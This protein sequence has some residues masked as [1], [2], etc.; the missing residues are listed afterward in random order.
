MSI[1]VCDC[2]C[3][4]SLWLRI[5]LS[6]SFVEQQAAEKPPSCHSSSWITMWRE[7]CPVIW[8]SLSHAKSA[9]PALPAGWHVNANAPWAAWWGIRYEM[10]AVESS[11]VR[12]LNELFFYAGNRSSRSQIRTEVTFTWQQCTKKEKSFPSRV[13]LTHYVKMMTFTRISQN[14][15]NGGL[16]MPGQ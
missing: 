15:Q 2:V 11:D 4:W 7:I 12:F 3:S 13:L 5:I 14:Y 6:S 1:P 8:L 9:P 16:F 10:H